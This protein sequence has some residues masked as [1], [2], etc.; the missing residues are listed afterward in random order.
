MHVQDAVETLSDNVGPPPRQPAQPEKTQRP[1]KAVGLSKPK[2]AD[3]Q[4]PPG[5]SKPAGLSKPG[6]GVAKAGNSTG[7]E[8]T[9]KKSGRV[10]SANVE[11]PQ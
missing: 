9:K 4:K 11:S 7:A 10:G 2:K 1:V 3:P 6:K 8:A 5:S